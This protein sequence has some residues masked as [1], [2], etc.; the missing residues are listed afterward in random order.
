MA[1]LRVGEGQQYATLEAAAAA[2]RPGD[3]VIVHEG[4]YRETLRPPGGTTWRGAAGERAI[5]DGGWSRD[6]MV[7]ADAQVNQVLINKPGVTLRGFEIRNV[8]GKGVAVAAGGDGFTMEG[9]EIHH[10]VSG[11]FAANGTSTLIRN[12]TIRG[13]H[14]HDISMSGIWRETPVSGCF[15][16]RFCHDVLV[17]DT[18]IERGYGEGIAAGVQSVGVTFRRVTVH[19]TAH[20]LM[21]VSNRAQDVVIEDC[22]LYQSGLDEFRQGDGDVGAG[23]VVGDEVGVRSEG[24]QHA[25]NVT[26]RGCLVV[27]AGS[28]FGIRNNK[29][30][31]GGRPDGYDTTIQNL[32]VER[33]TFVA[34]PDTRHGLGLSENPWG[35]GPVAGIIRDCVFVLDRL[36]AGAAINS[37][38]S[39]VQVAGNWWTAGVPAG[40]PASNRPMSLAA[41][42]DP[43][44][45]PASPLN[46]DNYRPAAGGPLVDA[47]GAAVAGALGPAGPTPPPPPPPP[48]P[49]P[50]P[51]EGPD[52]AALLELAA[53]IGEQ[54]AVANM[55]GE[56]ARE[57]LGELLLRLDEYRVGE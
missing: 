32:R 14:V 49:D 2:A 24:W 10:T 55:A 53:S 4:V 36:S 1:E 28:L 39:G 12:L 46:L 27:N 15:L 25:E 20:L 17:E 33:C 47:A 11:G 56:A 35:H 48:P 8:P 54:L 57:A 50:D 23:P 37:D 41:L 42:V 9:C 18:E 29:K 26:M 31:S 40:L 51:E 45:R 21:Y 52:W 43:L 19:D 34:G 3:E 6:H 13:C 7:D 22:I 30:Y 38:A 16:F 5:I 44:A